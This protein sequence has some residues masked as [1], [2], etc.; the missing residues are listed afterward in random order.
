MEGSLPKP[1]NVPKVEEVKAQAGW[2]DVGRSFQ[3]LER[4]VLTVV[5]LRHEKTPAAQATGGAGVLPT[6]VIRYGGNN[7]NEERE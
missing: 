7:C 4:V 5:Q 2:G 6:P 3:T 1:V